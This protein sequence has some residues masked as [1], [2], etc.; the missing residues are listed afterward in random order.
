MRRKVIPEL[1]KERTALNR[2]VDSAAASE[3]ALQWLS[4]K[5]PYEAMAKS[6]S[7]LPECMEKT[8]G[9]AWSTGL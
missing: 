8:E 4:K 3:I 5:A 2:S 6:P 7:A 1:L 9:L